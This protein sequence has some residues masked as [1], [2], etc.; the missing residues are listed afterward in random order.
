MAMIHFKTI[1]KF[2][3][4]FIFLYVVY[5]GSF[6]ILG[7][8]IQ[9]R[10]RKWRAEVII[11][12]PKSIKHTLGEWKRLVGGMWGR[13]SRNKNDE[14]KAEIWIPCFP[15]RS[16]CFLQR[17]HRTV[18]AN[19]HRLECDTFFHMHWNCGKIMLQTA[20][21]RFLSIAP[22]GLLMANATIPGELNSPP[23]S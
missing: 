13:G 22:D 21:G 5:L 15:S 6:L 19:G 4:R 10:L 8:G 20:S 12:F 3:L 1:L 9:H 17:R 11:R 18:M 2:G 14:K 23:A 16:Q 7:S